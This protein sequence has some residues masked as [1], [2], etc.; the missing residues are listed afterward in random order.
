[1]LLAAYLLLDINIEKGDNSMLWHVIL[2]LEEAIE[3]SPTFVQF[4]LLL[5]FLYSGLGAYGACDKLIW[6]DIEVC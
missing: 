3:S 6:M 4:K 1:M 2:I 5:L